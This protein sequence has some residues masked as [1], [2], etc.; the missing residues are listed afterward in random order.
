MRKLDLK[1][2][3]VTKWVYGSTIR[4]YKFRVWDNEFRF[5]VIWDEPGYLATIVYSFWD[6]YAKS[7]WNVEYS[8][9]WFKT[10]EQAIKFSEQFI[11]RLIRDWKT[12]IWL[13]REYEIY[14]K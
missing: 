6:V 8:F 2:F 7:N 9:S 3:E 1:D 12:F 11:S 14:N 10:V 4:S 13:M 5:R